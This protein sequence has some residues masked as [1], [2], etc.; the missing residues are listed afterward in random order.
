MLIL[1]AGISTSLVSYLFTDHSHVNSVSPVISLP[2]LGKPLPFPHLDLLSSSLLLGLA[3]AAGV[4]LTASPLSLRESPRPES[5]EEVFLSLRLAL[6]FRRASWML[7]LDDDSQ[8]PLTSLGFLRPGTDP[9]LSSSADAKSLRS[10]SSV[11]P[12]ETKHCHVCWRGDDV[13]TQQPHDDRLK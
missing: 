11:E 4:P 10:T 3:G 7:L 8:L 1:G 13:I 9:P 6:A 12:E 2:F 5:L